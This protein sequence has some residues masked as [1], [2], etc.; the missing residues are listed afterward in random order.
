MGKGLRFQGELLWWGPIPL[1]PSS[2]GRELGSREGRHTWLPEADRS[3]MQ[4][5]IME[6]LKL[7]KCTFTHKF[8]HKLNVSF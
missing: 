8:T 3:Q 6:P 2:Q 4:V 1:L 7:K 5:T